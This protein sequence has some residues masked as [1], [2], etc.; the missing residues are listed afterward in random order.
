MAA[1]MSMPDKLNI[2]LG[3]GG[4]YGFNLTSP[5]SI[6]KL[7]FQFSEACEKRFIM[8]DH[9]G[10]KRR[11]IFH[12]ALLRE[13]PFS[14]PDPS[15]VSDGMQHCFKGPGAGAIDK[16][17]E[18][19]IGIPTGDNHT[20]L[21][22]RL[23]AYR[24]TMASAFSVLQRIQSN[25]LWSSLDMEEEDTSLKFPSI[26]SE[27]ES[28]SRVSGNLQGPCASGW[29]ELMHED[30]E[31]L[32]ALL[33]SDDEISTGNSPSEVTPNNSTNFNEN[34]YCTNSRKRR[35][36]EESEVN[37]RFSVEARDAFACGGCKHSP[38]GVSPMPITSSELL[39]I[40]SSPCK[41]TG[42]SRVFEKRLQNRAMINMPTYTRSESSSTN[43]RYSCRASLL[44]QFGSAKQSRKNKIKQT[45]QILRSI[46]PGGDCMDTAIVLDQAIG[47]VKS[48]QMKVQQLEAKKLH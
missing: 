1:P 24:E 40:P 18:T 7:E 48:L 45:V 11:I 34:T 13:F 22:S 3:G 44:Q 15:K 17:K 27:S 4:C 26:I 30:T 2:K 31:D 6:E 23:M 10:S 21:N 25:S 29:H 42:E 47:Y 8:F 20:D 46:I 16:E 33:S 12:P 37:S 28:S 41:I 36:S 19:T 43:N 14:L 32:E 5:S 9:S 39:S 35:N 38:V